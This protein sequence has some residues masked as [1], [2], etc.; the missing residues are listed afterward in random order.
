VGNFEPQVIGAE[1]PVEPTPSE[2]AAIDERRKLRIKGYLTLLKDPNLNFRW[3]AAE[4]L[5]V[6]GDSTAVEPLYMHSK[7][8]L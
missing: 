7:T 6:E 1:S 8:H 3:R 2:F 4:A 5:G